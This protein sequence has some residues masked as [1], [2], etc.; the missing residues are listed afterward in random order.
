M[1][2]GPQFEKYRDRQLKILEVNYD[3][4]KIS[5]PPKDLSHVTTMELDEVEDIVKENKLPRSIIKVADKSP[6]KL[7][8]ATAKKYRLD[9]LSEEA[10]ILSE[11]WNTIAFYF[12]DKF[13]RRRPEEILKE[14][15]K[16]FP[17]NAPSS[18][19]SPSYPSGHS[20]LGYGLAEFYKEKYPYLAEEWDNIADVIAHSRLQLGVHFPSDNKAS[21]R[22][23]EQ[24]TEQQKTASERLR[25]TIFGVDPEGNLLHGFGGQGFYKFP[26]GGVDPG[27]SLSEAAKRELLEEAGYDVESIEELPGL[28]TTDAV[29]SSSAKGHMGHGSSRTKYLLAR[30]GKRNES[31]LG[32]EGDAIANLQTAPIEEVL[33]GLEGDMLFGSGVAESNYTALSKLKELL[34]KTSSDKLESQNVIYERLKP[35]LPEGTHHVSGGLPDAKGISD[36]DIYLPTNKHTGLLDTLPKGTFISKSSP[37]KTIYTIP[38]FGREVNLYAT[39]DPRKDESILHR[40]TLLAL[41]D[42]FPELEELAYAAKAGG[43]KSEPAWAKVLG[44][45]GDPY[46]LMKDTDSMLEAAKRVSKSVLRRIKRGSVGLKKTAAST[47]GGFLTRGDMSPP[48]EADL[49]YAHLVPAK[50]KRKRKD[51]EEAVLRVKEEI[52]R[53]SLEDIE[54]SKLVASG[55]PMEEIIARELIDP[56]TS[57]DNWKLTPEEYKQFRYSVI[58]DKKKLYPVARPFALAERYGIDL[59]LPED[60]ANE[61]IR[62]IKAFRNFSYPSFHTARG[63]F[64]AE[65]AR[66]LVPEDKQHLVDELISRIG[67]TRIQQ[68]V[69]S[70]Q[71]VEAGELL[72]REAAK[73]YKEK[74]IKTS[75]LK[76]N[77]SDLSVLTSEKTSSAKEQLKHILVTGHSGAGKTT[78]A[79][80]LAEQLGM[81]RHRLDVTTGPIMEAEYPEYWDKGTL[82]YP[83]DVS[84]RV[85]QQALSLGKP[86]VIEGAHILELPELT[87]GYKR[88]L[89]DTPEDRVVEQRAQREYRNQGRKGK[90]YRPIEKHR[91]AAKELVDH[92]RDIVNNF[93]NQPGVESIVPEVK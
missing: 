15:D 66:D 33:Q 42:Q 8:T 76:K 59:G 63:A 82:G 84:T 26:G 5:S 29:A 88:I 44:L 16:E 85:I 14:H 92:Y 90:P 37:T 11:D 18:A 39:L 65:T 77:A 10:Q 31:L 4:I 53:A 57:R 22:I 46:E 21:K 43:L 87:E 79:R 72:G 25:T 24:I 61:E 19:E 38:G 32:S 68:G 40:K 20:M 81:P 13:K 6:V 55:L 83:E 69:H 1:K 7:F 35:F 74:G 70:H 17:I 23:V 9:P 28:D 73:I 3:N 41:A 78:Y 54:Y 45:A 36:V 49:N 71:D 86:H 89:I 34:S 56:F 62:G 91:E 47:R 27:E 93:R 67:R 12:K 50:P 75:G 51:L 2:F 60:I 80:Q 30:L 58:K 52:A 48:T 64:L